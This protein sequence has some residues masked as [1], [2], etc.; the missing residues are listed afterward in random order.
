MSGVR[1]G[2]PV[3][4]VSRQRVPVMIRAYR[5]VGQGVAYLLFALAVGYFATDPVYTPVKKDDALIRL[6]F[7]HA[8][9]LKEPCREMTP[10]EMAKLPPNMRRAVECPRERLPV[11]VELWLNGK[12]IYDDVLL[13]SGLWKDGASYAYA[14]FPVPAGAYHLVARLRDSARTEGF[15]YQQEADIELA[16]LQSYVI[17]FRGETGG[18][19]FP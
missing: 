13:P 4:R 10:E 18:F 6:S 1:P 12:L 2:P 19:I 3:R 15:D 14:R 8:G 5:F 9:Q 11:V 16:P 7:S 17:D